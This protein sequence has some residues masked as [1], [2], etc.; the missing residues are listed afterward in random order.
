MSAIGMYRLTLPDTVQVFR[1]LADESRL[2]IVRLLIEQGEMR[3]AALCG[4][5]GQSQPAVSHHLTLL[6]IGRLVSCR[7]CGR[8]VFYRICAP[9]VADLLQLTCGG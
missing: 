4:A 6:R 8:N 9:V 1:L 7:R 3:V 2:R 5:L